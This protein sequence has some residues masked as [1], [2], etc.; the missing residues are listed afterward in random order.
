MHSGSIYLFFSFFLC[1]AGCSLLQSRPPGHTTF[2]ND[3]EFEWVADSTEHFFIYYETGALN[4]DRLEQVKKDVEASYKHNLI[5]LNESDYERTIYVFIVDSRERMKDLVGGETNGIAFPETH[6]VCY[7]VNENMLLS[8]KHE[9]LHVMAMNLWGEPEPWINEGMAVFSDGHWHNHD[10]DAL[11]KHLLEEGELFPVKE[12]VSSFHNHNDLVSYPQS[13]SFVK[14]IYEKFG[15]DAV[16]ALWQ[17]GV[18]S[19]EE[20]IGMN[21]L[22]L[23]KEWLQAIEKKRGIATDYQFN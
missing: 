2:L 7:I 17:N 5:V 1:I 14:F 8:A 11:A 15:V 22:S 9:L 3:R 18:A 20:V 23:E 19:S 12:M 10:L 6:V 13:G 16:K 21:V 4:K